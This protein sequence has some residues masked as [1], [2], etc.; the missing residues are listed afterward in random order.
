MFYR[1]SVLELQFVKKLKWGD[2]DFTLKG[3]QMGPLLVLVCPYFMENV[4]ATCKIVSLLCSSDHFL[5][6]N[7]I[8]FFFGN[9]NSKLIWKKVLFLTLFYTF[10]VTRE[11]TQKFLQH[12]PYLTLIH[13]RIFFCSPYWLFAL[14]ILSKLQIYHVLFLF[15]VAP[16]VVVVV[17]FFFF[18]PL[19]SNQ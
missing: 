17:V 9:Q 16:G 12:I 1:I 15:G 18:E 10:L 2:L 5:L 6:K 3:T 13:V 4:I 8:I 14:Q 7:V 19:W 11:K